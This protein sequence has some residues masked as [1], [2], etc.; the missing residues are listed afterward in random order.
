MSKSQRLVPALMLNDRSPRRCCRD[1]TRR[2]SRRGRLHFDRSSISQPEWSCTLG[3]NITLT[4]SDG[5]K[6]GGY[7]AEPQE[8]PRG[9]WVGIQEF[10][11]VTPPTR[12]LCDR[13]AAIASPPTAPAVFDRIQPNFE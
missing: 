8:K 4:A 7:R 5:F 1:I 12:A 3:T 10:F 2:P 13:F 6:L 11:G 9:G